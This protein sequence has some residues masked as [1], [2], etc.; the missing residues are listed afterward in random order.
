MA[1]KLGKQEAKLAQETRV[2]LVTYP[3]ASERWESLIG[4]FMS[5]GAAAPMLTES[6]ALPPGA[7]ELARELRPLIEQPDAVL[8]WSPPM[9]VNG[10]FD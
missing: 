5:S 3:P 4:E 8:L 9:S 10:R 1:I 7:A 2:T 6:V